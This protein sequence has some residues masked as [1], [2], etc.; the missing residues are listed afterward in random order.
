MRVC[1]VFVLCVCVWYGAF[2]SD[3]KCVC[4]VCVKEGGRIYLFFESVCG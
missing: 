4:G 2:V 1:V 3:R